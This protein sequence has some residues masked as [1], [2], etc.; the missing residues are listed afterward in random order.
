MKAPEETQGEVLAFG[1]AIDELEGILRRIEEEEIDVD[2]LAVAR[3]RV[4]QHNTRGQNSPLPGNPRSPGC[5]QLEH[6]RPG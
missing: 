3:R 6:L 4:P 2:E 5:T 1:E